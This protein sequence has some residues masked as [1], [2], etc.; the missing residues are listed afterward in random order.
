MNG[1]ES[2]VRTLVKG[3]VEVCFANP[4]TSEMHFVGALDRVEGMRCVLG[5]FEGVCS[6]AADGYYRM[7][8]RP[9]STLLHLGPGLANAAANLHNAKK[10]GSG[11]VNIV[12]EHALYH[13]KYDTPLTADIEGIARPFSHWVKTSP[14]AKTVASDG[15]AAIQAARVAPGQIA[16]LILPADTAW[17]EADGVADTPAPPPPQKPANETVVAAAKALKNGQP[18]MLFLG[19]RSL[20]ARGLELAG[21]IAARTGCRVQAAGGTARIER[22]AGRVPVLRLHF[23]VETALEML[24]GTKHM[25][26][27]GAK[28]PAAFFAYP[29]KPS[30]LVPEGCEVTTLC[31]VDGDPL[32]ALEALA[33]ELGALK[34][35]PANVASSKRPDRPTG[36][37]TPEGLGAALGATLPE[38]AIVVDESVTTGRGFFPHS[39]GAPPHDWLNNM[40]GSIGFGG[41][42]AVGAAVACPDR[43]VIAMIGDGSA[44]YTIQSLWTMARENLDV[45]VMIFSNRSYKILYSQLA[46]VGAANPGPRA[47]DMLTLD[48]PTLDFTL[49]AKSMGVPAAKALDLEELTKQL[50]YA[51]SQKG[52]YLIDVVM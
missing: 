36:K 37:F 49:M 1:A 27:C 41:P 32:A 11:I 7:T 38:G 14:T 8:D 40:G 22:G 12:G 3:G 25:V 51:M 29:G 35:K 52:P 43:K 30:V 19:G 46:D 13:I 20:R 15:A 44:M 2:L 4:G 45:C 47:I 28:P 26:L 33:A 10:A 50:T 24:K 17:T 31:P 6:G 18:A 21:K 34:E 5:L 48:R 9:A 42:V 39:A 23:V 16:T